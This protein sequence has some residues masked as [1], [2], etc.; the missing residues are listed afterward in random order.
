MATKDRKRSGQ[1]F[2]STPLL[3]RAREALRD[4]VIN[5]ARARQSAT[6]IESAARRGRDWAAASVAA[7]AAGV[8][9]KQ[10]GELDA[11]RDSLRRSVRAARR[12][13]QPTL[14][15]EVRVSLAGTLTLQGR[16]VDALTEIEAALSDLDGVPA[17]K[18][19]TQQ[20]AILQSVGRADEAFRTFRLAL[21]A[22]LRA[23]EAEWAVRALSNRSLL[24]IGNRSFRLAE[25]D[26]LTAQR[27]CD[28]NDLHYLAA[29]VE[30]NL[31][32]LKASRGEVIAALEH[33]GR[34]QQRYAAINVEVGELAE[35]RARL[36]LSVRLVDDARDAVDTAIA[37]HRRQGRPLQVMDDELLLST[38][39]LV[40]GDVA[41][42][43]RA[44]RHALSG[45]RRYHRANGAAL[46]RY[47]LLQATIA[48][49]PA[50]VTVGQARQ[51]ADELAA[52]GWLVPSLEARVLAGGLALQRGRRA[53]ARRELALAARARSTG[54]AD[55]RA[56]AWLAEALLRRADGRR[57]A[58]T[59]AINRGI[60]L[61]ED[62]QA[63]LGATELRAHVSLYR[64]ALAAE[65][66]SMAI[67][68]RQPRRI[69]SLVE[70]G[71]ASALLLRPPR[72]PNDRVLSTAL[73]DLRMTT[74]EIEQRRTAGRPTTELLQRQ[75]RL[76]RVIADRCR[77]L[78]ALARPARAAPRSFTELTTQLGTELALVEFVESGGRLAAVT[79]VAG[80]AGF[81]D[82]GAA[83][84]LRND[85]RSLGFALRR[86]AGPQAN[87][88]RRAAA[89][90]ALRSLRIRVDRQLFEPIRAALGDRGLV[91]VPSAGLQAVPWSVL[92]TCAGRPVTVSPSARLWLQARNTAL[93]AP[94]RGVVVAAGPGL[95][96]AHA[97]A[98][99]IA[100]MYPEA[101]CLADGAA[102]VAATLAAID[103]AGLVHL[104][105]HGR[106]RSDNPFFSSLVLADGPVVV[107][108]LQRLHDAP[109]H[110]VLAAC[111]AAVAGSVTVDETLGLAMAMLA[112]G[113]ASLVAPLTSI[114][115]H[116]TVDLMRRYHR[117]LRD[118]DGPA[119]ALARI[120]RNP[121]EDGDPAAAA[122]ANFVCL[123]AGHV[124]VPTAAGPD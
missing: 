14:A 28:A 85:L 35:A 77:Q 100:Q 103:G 107:Y 39:A 95:P 27:L 74:Q 31:G 26:L 15:G 12:S 89:T 65:G 2:A 22:L 92:P 38:I 23:G 36:L 116:V 93:H 96:G 11:S 40:Q 112:M 57:E 52:T 94:T 55:A 60:S 42:A 62:Y 90:S 41:I 113:T 80:R 61:V 18:A 75:V 30:H 10:L 101:V 43:A 24:H 33:Y 25:A 8:A 82:L 118:G 124:R 7:H 34:A 106:L 102:S 110:L 120:Q 121:A 87:D 19:R 123:G 1:E 122:A 69:L 81:D 109:A 115:D 86:L 108:E 71:R 97:E 20:A 98:I 4:A 5:P 104:A 105:A 67:E 68:D 9:A 53:E 79:V 3:G 88:A 58:A 99:G 76:E 114:G 117:G 49:R 13:G 51:A 21:R 59:R 84:P 46:A 64:G 16:P 45:Y 32:W 48:E 17:A 66:L 37:I 44:A 54:P 6:E 91:V 111:E 63:T 70:R 56:R 72:P 50:K 47:A 119:Q 78:P 29:V 83:E 73:T